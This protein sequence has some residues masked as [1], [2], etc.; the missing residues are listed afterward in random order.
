MLVGVG[1]W[2]G[3]VPQ[4]SIKTSSRRS[5]SL[6][7]RLQLLLLKTWVSNRAVGKHQANQLAVRFYGLP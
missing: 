3:A 2:G 1:S 5:R 6:R 7:A 4:P